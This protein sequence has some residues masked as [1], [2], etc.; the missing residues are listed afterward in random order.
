MRYADVPASLNELEE[1]V[2]KTWGEEGTFQQTLEASKGGEEFVFFEGPPTANGRPGLH[3][4]IS[5]TLKDLF[6][7]YQAQ[8]GKHVTRIAGW[9]THGLPVEIEAQKALG[10]SD[11]MEIEE[12]G[13]AWFNEQCRQSVFTYK[14][15]WEQ[16]SERIGYWLDYSKP[17][18]TFRPEYVESV[19]WILKELSKR[20]LLYRGHKVV[21]WCP[22]DQTVLSSHELSLGYKDVEDPS[23]YVTMELL[24]G[25]GRHLLVWTTTPWTLVSN[26]ALAVNPDLTY[27]EVAH[28]SQT[29]VMSRG[30]AEAL[31]EA[32]QVGQEVAADSLIGATYQRPFELI[33]DV[34]GRAWEIVAGSFV[35]DDEGS[36]VV[37]MAPAYGADDY[38][39]GKTHGLAFLDP[40]RADGTFPEGMPLVGGMFFKEADDVLL[41]DLSSRGLVF[42]ASKEVHSYPHCWRCATP[43]VYMARHSWFARTSTLRDDLL[44]NNSKINWYPPEVG[45]G[46]FGEWLKGNVDWALSRDRYWGTP[47]PAWVSDDDPSRVEWIGSLEELGEKVGGL[48]DDFDPH[49][50]FIDEL[51]WACSE[52]GATMR[53]TPEVLDVWF[54]SGSMPWAQWHYPFE[55][56]ES[57]DRHFPADYICEAVDQTRGWFYSLH[58][59]STMLGLGPAFK[60]V[61]VNDMILDADGQKMSKSKGNVVDPWEAIEAHGADGIRWHM[62][63]VSNPWLPKQFDGA[64]VTS[65]A[66]FFDTLLN[67]YKFFALYAN[68]EDWQPTEGRPDVSQRTLL[69]RW[70]LSR[71]HSLVSEVR[72]ELDGYQPTKAYRLVADFVDSELSNWY[73]RR[74]RSRFWTNEDAADQTAAFWSLFEALRV[75]ALLLG[76]VVP[77]VSDWLHRSLTGASS[78]LSGFP[79][80]DRGLID[81]ELEDQMRHV[82]VLATLGRAAREEAKIRVRQPL[83]SMRAVVPG[84]PVAG[85][86]LEVLKDELNVK[87]VEF[88][89][90]ADG[91]V[92]LSARPNYRAL[93]SRFG[94]ATEA[95]ATAIRALTEEQLATFRSGKGLVVEVDGAERTLEPDD[96]DVVE[97]AQG[98][99]V[100]RT[101]G[102]YTVALDTTL[103]ATLVSEGLARELINRVQR[104]RKDSGLEITDRIVL[105]V[106]GSGPVQS[107][108]TDHADSI[109]KE[110]LAVTLGVSEGLSESYD[111]Q[112]NVELDG[113]AVVLGLSRA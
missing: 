38:E 82:R 98:D 96:L 108:A 88:Q 36:G 57:F 6:C 89:A 60:N 59:I 5:R 22:R 68:V 17:Y 49:R 28:E 19:W 106:G 86:A 7:R 37:H 46:R 102:G 104:L 2:L 4:I 11:K 12:R 39:M 3:H 45:E 64:A 66:R 77:F 32:E 18:V 47:L 51:T 63:T 34:E 20:D 94:K 31:F 92:T 35:S 73:V 87:A 61:I 65:S 14:E 42:R 50:P 21:P 53:R 84:A 69:D 58:A 62:I 52:T 110:T 25:S 72:S 67:T 111:H 112:K 97:E 71:L 78:H 55:N 8:Q 80:V 24:D 93:G 23:L 103:S 26:V 79:E 10:I 107:A 15:E 74:S 75:V 13:I 85:G 27:V 40:V 90:S 41:D 70:L 99:W 44:E 16:L 101:E 9:D 29:L 56:Q 33:E 30:R 48:P 113:E 81:P 43:L 109:C 91:L 54:D 95:A 76:P 100:V 1:F 105:G 83:G